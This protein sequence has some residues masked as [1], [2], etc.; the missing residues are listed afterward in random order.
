M[1]LISG[2]KSAISAVDGAAVDLKAA[3][4]ECARTAKEVTVL[5]HS[6]LAAS[7]S[8]HDTSE[9]ARVIIRLLKPVAEQLEEIT[10]NIRDI[11]VSTRNRSETPTG[12]IFSE[13]L[14][15]LGRR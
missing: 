2:L 9:E 8:C 5:S 3:A 13:I 15:R 6:A 4:Q 12:A 7:K 1:Q 10:K 14:S 11:I